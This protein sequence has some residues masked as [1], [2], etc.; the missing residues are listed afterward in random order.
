LAGAR[1]LLYLLIGQ[2]E[3]HRVFVF[4]KRHGALT[5]PCMPFA[6]AV[7]GSPFMKYHFMNRNKQAGN[8]YR[9]S[10]VASASGLG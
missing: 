10:G 3:I 9:I 4:P 7:C 6:A 5:R 8:R 1:L 2:H